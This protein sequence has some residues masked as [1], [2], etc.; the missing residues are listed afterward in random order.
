MGPLSR[1]F[2]DPTHGHYS[3]RDAAE[4][5]TRRAVARLSRAFTLRR[6]FELLILLLRS[7][8]D[9]EAEL[10]ALR[11][12]IAYFGTRSGARLPTA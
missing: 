3:P 1:I 4:S 10:L 8:A 5:G 2:L 6:L 9:N 12:E 11:H 7:E